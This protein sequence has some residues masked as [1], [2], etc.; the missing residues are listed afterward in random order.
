MILKETNL[1]LNLNFHFSY[2]QFEAL[3]IIFV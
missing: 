1:D 2:G 3:A